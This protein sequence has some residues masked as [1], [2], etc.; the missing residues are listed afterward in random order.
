MQ[1]HLQNRPY[2]FFKYRR[3]IIP[4]R[5][6]HTSTYV[7]KYASV[8][9]NIANKIL[10]EKQRKG[11]NDYKNTTH[12]VNMLYRLLVQPLIQYVHYFLYMTFL[13]FLLIL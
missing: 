3:G 6:R 8:T 2:Y 1:L 9:N 12:S 4:I 10:Q 13:I 11:Y 7:S 5:S